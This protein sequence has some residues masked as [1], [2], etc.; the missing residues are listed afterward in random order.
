MSFTS[1]ARDRRHDSACSQRKRRI[2]SN[3]VPISNRIAE[4]SNSERNSCGQ[5]AWD[6]IPSLS[7][8][9]FTNKAR[10]R[11]HDSA[12]SQRQRRIGSHR[13]RVE[14]P[15]GRFLTASRGVGGAVAPLKIGME[16]QSTCRTCRSVVPVRQTFQ[17][18]RISSVKKPASWCC[19]L[20]RSCYASRF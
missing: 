3:R 16:S 8:M 9:R 7:G 2:N 20:K 14:Q 10:D 1:N 19:T 6:S 17:A 12:C 15:R 13:T 11:R 5:V 18:S 4:P